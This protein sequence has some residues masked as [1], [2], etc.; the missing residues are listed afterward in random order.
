MWL[1]GHN[2]LDHNKHMLELTFGGKCRYTTVKLKYADYGRILFFFMKIMDLLKWNFYLFNYEKNWCQCW[3]KTA[4]IIER[5][6]SGSNHPTGKNFFD[7]YSYLN[8]SFFSF[9]MLLNWTIMF[10]LLYIIENK[11]YEKFNKMKI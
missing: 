3:S 9:W 7:K 8:V 4:Q 11:V 2:G 6:I 10:P 1:S 5:F